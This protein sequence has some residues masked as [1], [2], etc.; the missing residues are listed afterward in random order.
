[1]T[2]PKR[3]TSE[4]FIFNP[5]RKKGEYCYDTSPCATKEIY[6]LI[7]QKGI[8]EIH[9][10]MKT[11]L[12]TRKKM[13]G[14]AKK[15]FYGFSDTELF[16]DL[17]TGNHIQLAAKPKEYLQKKS[18]HNFEFQFPELLQNEDTYLLVQTYHFLEKKL[19]KIAFKNRVQDALDGFGADISLGE[20]LHNA[21]TSVRWLKKLHPKKFLS[22]LGG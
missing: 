7:G 17:E 8:D 10:I 2:Y 3:F 13:F 18:R 19:G 20:K 1:M 4:R 16:F 11:M 12:E 6:E 22:I 5:N 15:E 9:A 14:C 21:E